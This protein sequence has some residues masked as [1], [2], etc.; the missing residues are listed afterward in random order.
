MQT[1]TSDLVKSVDETDNLKKGLS[2]VLRKYRDGD[3]DIVQDIRFT[4]F[5]VQ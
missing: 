4:Q 3:E 2:S 5:I 1:L